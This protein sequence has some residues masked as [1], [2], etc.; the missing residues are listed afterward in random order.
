MQLYFYVSLTHKQ[1]ETYGRVLSTVAI[2]A[3]VLKHQAISI[4][5]AEQTSIALDRF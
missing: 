5:S 2:D 1:L 3:L 4:H